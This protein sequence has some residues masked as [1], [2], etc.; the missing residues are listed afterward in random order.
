MRTELAV[1]RSE[2]V[3]RPELATFRQLLAFADKSGQ[4]EAERSWAL[5]KAL[6]LA[7]APYGDGALLVEIALTDG[8]LETAWSAARELGPGRQWRALAD[9]SRD[10]APR[11][12]AELY[13]EDV[14]KDLTYA[15]TQKYESIAARLV[16]MRDLCQRAG[17]EADF[18]DYLAELRETYR[19]RTSLMSALDRRGL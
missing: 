15:D 18:A 2:F 13:R 6:E 17:A 9:A 5:A 11:E 14:A 3:R 7:A 1:L 4:E 8:D 10:F 16:A 19:R 12:A